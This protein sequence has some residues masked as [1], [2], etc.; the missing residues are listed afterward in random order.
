M[1]SRCLVVDSV[2][3]GGCE[4]LE[5]PLGNDSVIRGLIINRER[6]CADSEMPVGGFAYPIAFNSTL[7]SLHLVQ[8]FVN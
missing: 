5:E 2:M 8:P 3:L 6:F 4:R 1:V 7:A